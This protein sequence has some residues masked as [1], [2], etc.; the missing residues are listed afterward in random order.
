MR[1][2]FSQVAVISFEND[3]AVFKNEQPIDIPTLRN[4]VDRLLLALVEN[5]E[6]ADKAVALF[7]RQNTLTIVLNIDCRQYLTKVAKA[8]PIH[9]TKLK[10]GKRHV[11]RS[12]ALFGLAL[13][14]NKDAC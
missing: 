14:T 4:L 1:P 9:R 3:I 13:R 7:E 12:T 11:I 5:R 10:I 2:V 8:P 6:V